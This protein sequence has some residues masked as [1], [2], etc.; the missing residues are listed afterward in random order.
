MTTRSE[1]AALTQLAVT[2]WHE[3][4]EILTERGE[5]YE[6]TDLNTWRPG[7]RNAWAELTGIRRALEA[8]GQRLDLSDLR[9]LHAA[10]H[11]DNPACAPASRTLQ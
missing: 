10:A 1:R 9:H 6:T 3:I 5:T 11:R 2:A 8:V 7:L 4:D